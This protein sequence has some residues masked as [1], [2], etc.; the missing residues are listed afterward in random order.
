M[1]SRS[2]DDDGAR[3]EAYCVAAYGGVVG[4]R[5]YSGLGWRK[6]FGETADDEDGGAERDGGAGDCEGGVSGVESCSG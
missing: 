6:G 2:V 4:V 3:E 5:V 1:K